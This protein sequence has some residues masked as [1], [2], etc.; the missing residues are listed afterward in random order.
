MSLHKNLRGQMKKY[1]RKKSRLDKI[2]DMIVNQKFAIAG[3]LAIILVTL[4]GLYFTSQFEVMDSR[5][6]I[7]SVNVDVPSL[8]DAY[9]KDLNMKKTHPAEANNLQ[10]DAKRNGIYTSKL[11]SI[12]KIA[13]SGE[14][15]NLVERIPTVRFSASSIP[16]FQ[17]FVN[18]SPIATFKEEKIAHNLLNTLKTKYNEE[19]SEIVEVSFFEKIEI[20]NTYIE[21]VDFDDFDDPEHIMAYIE[22]GTKEERKHK[23]VKGENYWTIAQL[24]GITPEDLEKANPGIPPERLQIDQM[25]SL[26]VPKPIISVKTVERVEYSEDIKFDVVYEKS[27]SYYIGETRTKSNGIYGEKSIIANLVKENGLLV[28]KE[29]VSETV[30]S[31]PVAK[32]VYTGTKL[33]PPRMGTGVL[34]YPLSKWGPVSS[35]FLDMRGRAWPHTGID[36]AVPT[37]TQVLAADGGVVIA[38]GWEGL[39]GYR[40]IINHGANIS[41]LYAHCS[42]L[43]VKVGDKVFKGQT[44]AYS[45]STGYS[46]GPHLHFEVRLNGR[47]QN[48]RNYI[49]F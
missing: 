36:V 16:V 3:T 11:D 2:I 26:I 21:I 4:A 32:V 15:T 14:T 27:E 30:L 46:T 7:V 38:S 13:A 19:E 29:I 35:E 18:N 39:G 22:K 44:I 45:G 1:N 40:I 33:P 37:G 10:T 12:E 9:A 6:G 49:D 42:S 8:E 41:T 20:V 47:Y 23:V 48:P 34:A 24:Y 43:V 17:L 28:N 31:K 5:P 25:I